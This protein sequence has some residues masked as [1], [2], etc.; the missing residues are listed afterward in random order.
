MQNPVSKSEFARIAGVNASTVTRIAKTILKNS[1][2]GNCIDTLHPDAADYLKKRNR[3][4]VAPPPK[5]RG[6]AVVKE[7]KKKA[8]AA[9]PAEEMIPEEISAFADMTLREV[10][11]RFGSDARFTDW[12]KALATIENIEDKRLKNAKAR[13]TLINRELVARGVIDPIDSMHRQL[14]TD[15]A[16]TIA[17]RVTAMHNAGRDM[18][19]I[20]RFVTGQISSFIK[21]VKPKI[22]RAMRH[23]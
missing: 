11:S 7:R 10:I 14:M 22:E 9:E 12:L 20:E 4:D 13:G 6:Q 18:T 8:A 15:G 16:R 2:I 21:P 1:C 17:R 23:V 5:P 19:E 3:E